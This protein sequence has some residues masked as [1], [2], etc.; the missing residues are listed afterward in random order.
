MKFQWLNQSVFSFEFATSGSNLNEIDGLFRVR[1]RMHRCFEC[2]VS[3]QTALYVMEEPW[4]FLLKM[5]VWLQVRSWP[6]MMLYFQWPGIESSSVSSVGWEVKFRACDHVSSLFL[7]ET[8]NWWLIMVERT[9]KA[10]L[11]GLNVIFG[12]KRWTEMVIYYTVTCLLWRSRKTLAKAVHWS[13][14]ER[15]PACNR[16]APGFTDSVTLCCAGNRFGV[17]EDWV[18]IY[19]FSKYRWRSS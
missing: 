7:K 17:S 6:R 10:H 13:Q 14:E 18:M 9:W 11:G 8:L 12:F 3:P 2:C 16:R 5:S 1:K 15:V 4:T 19:W